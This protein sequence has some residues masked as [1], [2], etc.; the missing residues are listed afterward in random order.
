MQQL[1]THGLSRGRITWDLDVSPLLLQGR[2][3]Q[4]RS[5]GKTQVC[6]ISSLNISLGNGSIDQ[7]DQFFVPSWL[8]R[9][10]RPSM[11]IFA[12]CEARHGWQILAFCAPFYFFSSN[13]D[14]A[15][16]DRTYCMT[17]AMCQLVETYNAY[18][19]IAVV[20]C[21]A[22]MS[23]LS[24]WLMCFWTAEWNQILLSIFQSI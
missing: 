23:Y 6:T 5:A 8:I 4:H 12:L 13:M 19:A 21:T 24:F 7:A 9:R 20:V 22:A 16:D 17:A 2:T 3:C 14:H 1:A 18:M 10:A 11:T 15:R